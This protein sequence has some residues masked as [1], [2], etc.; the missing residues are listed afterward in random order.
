MTGRTG[1]SDRSLAER[2]VGFKIQPVDVAYG[3]GLRVE[4]PFTTSD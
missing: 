3:E 1:A 2:I 4:K